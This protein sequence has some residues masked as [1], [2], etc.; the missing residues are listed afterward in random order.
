MRRN[1]EGVWMLEVAA[2]PIGG[3]CSKCLRFEGGASSLEQLVIRHALGEDVRRV[4]R[5][6]GASG[7]MM[8]PIP[9]SGI[10]VGV[11]GMEEA[12]RVSGI[13]DVIITAKEGQRLQKLPEGGS[14]MGFLFASAA[15]PEEVEN[16]LRASHA[17][18]RFE[19]AKTLEVMPL[20]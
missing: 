12:A 11:S 18:L 8:V 7:V 3:L 17:R 5:E 19:I 20:R 16:G 4:E 14:Y 15:T 1:D 10:Y 6:P 9:E 13:D 2:R